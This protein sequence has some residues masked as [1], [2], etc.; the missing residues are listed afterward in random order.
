MRLPR[1]V[2]GFTDGKLELEPI[3]GKLFKKI[4]HDIARK[5]QSEVIAFQSSAYPANHY[6]LDLQREGRTQSILLHDYFP[7]A[8]IAVYDGEQ[9]RT[10]ISSEEVAAEL[11]PFYEVLDTAF[12]NEAFEPASHDL[13]ECELKQ[14]HAWRAV[15]NGDV[16]FNCWD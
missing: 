3:D 16:V 9:R 2:T 12:L 14:V 6:R 11:R 5:L 15:T 10:F 4:G 1:G 13:A 8:A 7:Y